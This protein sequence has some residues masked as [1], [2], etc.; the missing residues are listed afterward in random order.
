LLK[1]WSILNER[2]EIDYSK[3]SVK[4]LVIACNGFCVDL[5]DRVKTHLESKLGAAK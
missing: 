4:E 2:S 3:L 1:K 5:L